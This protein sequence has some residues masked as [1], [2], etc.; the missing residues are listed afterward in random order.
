MI[1][2]SMTLQLGQDVFA[3]SAYGFALLYFRTYFDIKIDSQNIDMDE[4]GKLTHAQVAPSPPLHPI[5]L[6]TG[7]SSLNPKPETRNPKPSS[8]ALQANT[9]FRAEA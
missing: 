4:L 1:I 2:A 8:R 3:K 9:T 5:S 7:Y 6:A